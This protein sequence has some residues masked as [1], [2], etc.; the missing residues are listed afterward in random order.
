MRPTFSAAASPKFRRLPLV[1]LHATAPMLR[2]I[3]A[4]AAVPILVSSAAAQSLSATAEARALWKSVIGNLNQAAD[5]LPESMY[6]YR[7]TPDVRTTGE[8][9]AHIAGSQKMYCAMALGDKAPDEGDVEKT[10]KTKAAIVAAL[11]ESN[12]YCE[13]AYAQSDDKVKASVDIFGQQRS[14]YYALIANASHD[15]EHYGNIVTYM[16]LNKLVPPSSRPR[17]GR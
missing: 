17:T 9:F 2:A 5:E 14:R 15:G 6:A 10:A 3:L 8:L 13:R 16:R 7:P 11:K 12:A 1:T 4:A